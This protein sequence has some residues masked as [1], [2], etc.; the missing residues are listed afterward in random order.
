MSNA[1][2]EQRKKSE[3]L[4]RQSIYVACSHISVDVHITTKMLASNVLDCDQYKYSSRIIFSYTFT[5]EPNMKWIGYSVAE[6]WPFEIFQD[7]RSVVG[8]SSI[9]TL[10]SCTP[11]RYVRNASRE[12]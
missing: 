9:Y 12:E 3:S 11:L 7:A 5:L 2:A 1:H 10:M 8:R 4:T 6:R